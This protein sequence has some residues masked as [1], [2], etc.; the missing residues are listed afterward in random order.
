MSVSSHYV[1]ASDSSNCPSSLVSCRASYIRQSTCWDINKKFFSKTDICFKKNK[2]KGNVED[3]QKTLQKKAQAPWHSPPFQAIT[4]F[5]QC[6]IT[7]GLA[8]TTAL[9]CGT[10]CCSWTHQYFQIL[11]E[12]SLDLNS[13][14]H[15]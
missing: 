8:H 4:S 12:Q 7:H 14:S 5:H 3:S 1:K 6:S 11:L 10:I 2:R 13:V 9:T 15:L